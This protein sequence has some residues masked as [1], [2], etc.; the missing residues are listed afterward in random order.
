MNDFIRLRDCIGKKF[1]YDRIERCLLEDIDATT[2]ID[3]YKDI[4]KEIEG[5][6]ACSLYEVYY[7]KPDTKI[8]N[9]WTDERDI[10]AAITVLN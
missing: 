9:V 8:Y 7:D 4:K 1:T 6:G 2:E 3:R 10:I 5:I